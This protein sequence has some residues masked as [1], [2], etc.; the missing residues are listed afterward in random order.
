MVGAACTALRGDGRPCK[1]TPL[2]EE[3]F[4]FFHSPETAEEAADARRLGGLHRRK[5]KSV[6]AVY[7]FNGLR[8]IPDLTALLETASIETLAIENSINRNRTLVS[9]VSAAAKLLEVGELADRI[10]ALETAARLSR[11]VDDPVS[12]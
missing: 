8:T 6:S 9:I 10:A 11:P 5:R 2:R 1:A 3:A 7:G 12:D 4:C